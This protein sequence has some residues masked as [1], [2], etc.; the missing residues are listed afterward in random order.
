MTELPPHSIDSER[1]CLAAGLNDMVFLDDC[2]SVLR[3]PEAFYDIRHQIMYREMVNMRDQSLTCDAVSLYDR[4]RDL[5]VIEDAGGFS[6]LSELANS[7]YS[8][9]AAE[10]Y[11]EQVK[12]LWLKR[13]LIHT[14]MDLIEKAHGASPGETLLEQAQASL[15]QLYTDTTCLIDSKTAAG[16]LIDDLERR[17]QLQGRLSGISTGFSYFDHLTDGLQYGDQTIIGARP[18]IGKTAMGLNIFYHATVLCSVPAL[19]VSLEM[20]VAALM[21][22]MA[23]YAT[24][25]NMRELRR[26]SYTEGD[27][28]KFTAFQI[29]A[30]KAP[31]WFIDAVSGVDITTL[32]SEIRRACR[33]HGIKLVVIDYLQRIQADRRQE[34]KTYEVGDV[35]TRLAGLADQTDAAF[36]TLAQLNR[37]S[38]KDK[39][40]RPPRLSDLGDSKQ[41]EQDADTIGLI[42]RNR[43]EPVGEASLIVAKQRDGELGVVKLRFNGPMCRFEDMPKI[44]SGDRPYR[45]YVQD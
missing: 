14:A 44:E 15:E 38:E 11:V 8:V 16:L 23:C 13:K 40:P 28:K 22:R 32:G 10:Q 25:I 39:T 5:G 31:M 18:S 3:N 42:H 6:Y 29:K 35:S 1:A 34:K 9:S 45:N 24:E 27:F 37:D 12:D 19:F 4:I 43:E 17:H 26:G 7:F 21:R 30:V 33:K 41:I 2:R 20:S 36:L